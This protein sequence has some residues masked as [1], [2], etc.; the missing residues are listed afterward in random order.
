VSLRLANVRIIHDRNVTII[1]NKNYII[2][3]CKIKRT[4]ESGRVGIL[5]TN[6]NATMNKL[7]IENLKATMMQ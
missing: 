3:T 6:Y 7:E 4:A 1:I 5:N 2:S